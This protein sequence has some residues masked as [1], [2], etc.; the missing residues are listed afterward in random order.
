MEL[1]QGKI[2]ENVL[3]RSILK[4]IKLK[5]S[6][7]SNG[8]AV[9]ADC[10]CL[11]FKDGAN[12]LL[13][14]NPVIGDARQIYRAVNNIAASGGKPVGI[15]LTVLVPPAFSEDDL[16]NMTDEVTK[17]TDSLNVQIIG[18]HTEVTDAVNMPVLNVTAVG[19]ADAYIAPGGAHP[20]DD[21]V[22]TKWIGLEGTYRLAEAREE[23]LLK[24]FPHKY[25]YDAKNFDRFLS[26]IPEAAIAVKS[27]VTA[28]HDVTRG[29]IF[30]ALWELGAC[31]GVGLTVNLKEIPIKQET[32]EIC[33]FYDINPYELASTGALLCTTADGN[34]L[35][36]DLKA[37]GIEACIIGK[38]TDSNDRVVINDEIKRFLEPPKTDEILKILQNGV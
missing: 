27:G 22:L 24:R 25:I 31:A 38:I 34:G 30:A 17:I 12:V 16:Q 32:V 2:P 7:V 36:A 20:G 9:G 11:R 21:I 29:G 37:A 14:S 13:S 18:G 33:N 35:T 10:A 6:E 19:S 28:M 1:K 23:E 8:A 4:K 15:E 3:K 26:I 5:R